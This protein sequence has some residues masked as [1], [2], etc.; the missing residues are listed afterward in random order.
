M[1]ILT[2]LIIAVSNLFSFQN[3]MGFFPGIKK[4]L[5]FVRIP[6]KIPE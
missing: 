3:S 2:I 1:G 5:K 4:I 6:P